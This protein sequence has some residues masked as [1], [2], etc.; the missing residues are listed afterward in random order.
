MAGIMLI[1]TFSLGVILILAGT[2][3]YIV[4]L[5]HGGAETEGGL[6]ISLGK[7][8][9]LD[10]P[11]ASLAFV[12][13][14]LFLL[15]TGLSGALTIQAQEE[16]LESRNSFIQSS[17]PV[18]A[19]VSRIPPKELFEESRSATTAD[20]YPNL[21]KRALDSLG[22]LAQDEVLALTVLDSLSENTFGLAKIPPENAERFGNFLASVAE[23][24]PENIA[25]QIQAADLYRSLYE[26]TREKKY[27][28]AWGRLAKDVLAKDGL[29]ERQRFQAHQLLGLYL[30]SKD[31][32]EEA[33]NQLEEAR[34]T[35]PKEELYK[36]EYNLCNNYFLMGSS[37][38]A[39]PHCQESNRL[40][41]E[42][43]V[44]FWPP[45]FDL[46]A[47]SQK[48]GDYVG[49]SDLFI[50]CLEMARTRAEE[51]LL[52]RYLRSQAEL[53]RLCVIEAFNKHFYALCHKPSP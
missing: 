16:K 50:Q 2:V 14:G 36:L 12:G 42:G 41:R 24:F 13:L 32:F 17:T 40:A 39:E 6:K 37:D 47:I 26:S 33:L 23:R 53:A 44:V 28:D 49:A 1:I 8:L 5:H 4:R 52:I 43:N 20:P 27:Q 46:A 22:I 51:D 25:L 31:N 48:R 21:Q 45:V 15:I 9:S 11:R 19:A 3:A 34:R 18:L 10:T 38:Q 29:G 7:W 30:G 35:A